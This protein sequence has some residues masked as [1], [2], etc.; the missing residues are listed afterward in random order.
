MTSVL[1]VGED[2]L[3]LALL[4]RIVREVPELS[5]FRRDNMQGFGAMKRDAEKYRQTAK[6]GGLVVIALTDLDASACPAALVSEWLPHGGHPDF[7]LRVAVR[8]AEAWVLAD[9]ARFAKHFS[10]KLT[11]LPSAPDLCLDPKATLLSLVR[12]ARKARWRRMLPAGGHPIGPDY[13]DTLADFIRSTWSPEA[14]ATISA[15][16][17]RCRARVRDLA[18]RSGS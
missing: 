9:R 13:N 17:A 5:V 4:E 1:L 2:E 15:S 7:L 10:V 14:A 3:C 6:A 18:A 11:A 16:L 8:E 12:G